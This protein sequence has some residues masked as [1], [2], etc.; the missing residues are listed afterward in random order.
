V[1]RDRS[2]GPVL[3]MVR[4]KLNV[5]LAGTMRYAELKLNLPASLFSSSSQRVATNTANSSIQQDTSKDSSN[6]NALHEDEFGE[7]ELNDQDLV[8]AGK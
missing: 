4:L 1:R 6:C 3:E 5:S 7:S 2:I 8:E